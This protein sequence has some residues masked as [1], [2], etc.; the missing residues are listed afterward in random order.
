MLIFP[1]KSSSMMMW[2]ILI[3]VQSLIPI[4]IHQIYLL[5]SYCTVPSAIKQFVIFNPWKV[6]WNR[7]AFYQKFFVILPDL[8]YHLIRRD[9]GRLADVA[10]MSNPIVSLKQWLNGLKITN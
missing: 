3:K 6:P 7:I 10:F 9:S 8:L 1:V 2:Q 5:S 4:N